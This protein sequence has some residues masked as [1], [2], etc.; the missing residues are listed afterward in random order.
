[1]HPT[2]RHLLDHAPV[3]SDGAWGTQMQA[4]GLPVGASPDAWNLERADQVE[5]VARAYVKAGSQVILTN[6]FGASSVSLARH[7][8]ADKAAAINRAGAQISKRA[9][10]DRAVVFGSIGPCGK[11][12]MM[13]EISVEEMTQSFDE[14]ARALAEGGV[15]GV[16]IETM[17]DLDEAR[18]A[19]AAAK[20]TG[21]P[22][23]VSMTYSA[24]KNHDRTVMGVTPEQAVAALEDAGA[25]AVGANCGLGIADYVPICR[26]LHAATSLPIWI[27]PNAGMPEL[28]DG[29]ARYATTAAEFAIHA[30][31]LVEAGA[32]FV[33]GCC[34]S[35]PE[36]TVALAEALHAQSPSPAGSSPSKE[37]QP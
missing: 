5:A 25:D 13:D 14:Q 30:A 29:E 37:E 11:L 21:L 9:A 34:G 2:L 19:L 22:V 20:A 26:R 10:G 6:T 4:R 7:D 8:L 15:D 12:L 3:L 1:M 31:A 18:I 23:I 32:S 36:F 16:L 27:K 28:V 17:S 33:G 35:T 24:G